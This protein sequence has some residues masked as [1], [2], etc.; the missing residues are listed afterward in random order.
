MLDSSLISIAIFFLMLVW[1]FCFLFNAG[2]SYHCR[3]ANVTDEQI[4]AFWYRFPHLVRKVFIQLSFTDPKLKPDEFFLNVPLASIV[5]DLL[6]GGFIFT[7]LHLM[8]LQTMLISDDR[9]ARLNSFIIL[10]ISMSSF[11]FI[12]VILHRRLKSFK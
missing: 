2:I 9:I 7:I 5:S 8:L 12:V 10:L 1:S 6:I 4:Q 3:K 11:I